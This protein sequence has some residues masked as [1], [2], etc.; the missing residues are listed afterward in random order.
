MRRK[1]LTLTFTQLAGFS[2]A[3]MMTLTV[4]DVASAQGRN[5]YQAMLGETNQK[6]GEVSTEE[7]RRILTD[8]SAIVLDSRTRFQYV[9]GHILATR[10]IALPADAPPSEDVAAVERMVDGDKSRALMLYCNGPFCG[11]GKRISEDLVTAGFTS[12]RRYQLGIV[13][14]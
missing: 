10:N 8:G 12:V 4:A 6:T 11:A 5:V 1:L 9:A 2:L 13:A 7:L 3:A 14:G